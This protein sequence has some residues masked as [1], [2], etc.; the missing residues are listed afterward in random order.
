MSRFPPEFRD[1]I[2]GVNDMFP[3]RFMSMGR[4]QFGVDEHEY[5]F[6]RGEGHEHFCRNVGRWRLEAPIVGNAYLS[7]PVVCGAA[8]IIQP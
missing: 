4:S 5:L 7:E 3:R 1:T 6:S 2:K 8:G